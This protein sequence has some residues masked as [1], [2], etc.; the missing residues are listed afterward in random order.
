MIII[1][2]HSRAKNAIERDAAVS[3]F[4][5][6][7]ETAR[8][9]DGCLDFAITA[10]SLDPERVNIFECWRDQ[11]TLNAWRKIARGPKVVLREPQAKLYRSDKAEKPF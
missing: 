7:V 5:D 4:A 10:D 9:Q 3:A 1:A 6:M 8:Q 11:Q 2:G